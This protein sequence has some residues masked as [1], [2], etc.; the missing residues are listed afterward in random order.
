V[1]GRVPHHE[2]LIDYGLLVAACLGL[3]ATLAG[4]FT[5]ASASGPG[6]SAPT[7]VKVTAAKPSEYAFTLSRSSS[8]PWNAGTSTSTITFRITNRG[9]LAHSFKVCTAS[10]EGALVNTC[11]GKATKPLAPGK[12]A[13]LTVTFTARGTYEYLSSVPGQ[14]AKGMKGMLG[15]GVALT[16]SPTTTTTP[17]TTT[18]A[19]TSPPATPST[20][21]IPSAPPS[22]PDGSAGP[23]AAVWASAGCG[24]CHSF[25]EV[26]GNVG[27]DL[28]TRHPGPF[29]NGQLSPQQIADLI[30]Y[31]NSR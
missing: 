21:V 27:A 8:L 20:P 15:V 10:L 19:P 22:L 5:P 26:K 1:H 23:G 28:N 30:A 24:L 29:E 14:A 6:L 3:V 13:S 16:K 17:K 11:A 9:T 25:N 18:P 31:I 7:V 4:L 12:A 2:Q